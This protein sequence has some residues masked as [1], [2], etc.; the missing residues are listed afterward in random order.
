MNSETKSWSL[1]LF[2][3]RMVTD[4][5]TSAGGFAYA[6]PSARCMLCQVTVQLPASLLWATWAEIDKHPSVKDVYPKSLL[7][8]FKK[9]IISC[10]KKETKN[11]IHTSIS[12][13]SCINTPQEAELEGKPVHHFAVK[14]GEKIRLYICNDKIPALFFVLTE[15]TALV[16]TVY[17]GFS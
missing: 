12:F 6:A 10:L 2:V 3:Q 17:S 7:V 16:N 11:W 1:L 14:V 9:K 13:V 5:L 8:K 4:S 15:I